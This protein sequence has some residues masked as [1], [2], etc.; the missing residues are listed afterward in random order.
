MTAGTATAGAE[1]V[2]A[3]FQKQVLAKMLEHGVILG[4]ANIITTSENGELSVPTIDDTANGGAWTAEAGAITARLAPCRPILPC[5]LV[6]DP[7]YPCRQSS[8]APKAAAPWIQYGA[9]QWPSSRV[10]N[11]GMCRADRDRPR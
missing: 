3:E 4:E 2:P 6:L 7:V 8:L 5:T 11:S 9:S 1:L 10:Y